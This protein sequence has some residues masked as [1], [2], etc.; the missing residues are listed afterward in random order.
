MVK[1]E[2]LE[3]GN[4]DKCCGCN[5]CI[6]SCPRKCLDIIYDEEG[7]NYPI[8]K[9]SDMCIH[10]GKCKLVCPME[11]NKCLN[12]NRV[13]YGMVNKNKGELLKSSS[14]GVFIQLA[15]NVLKNNGIVYGVTFS[16]NK[17]IYCR[18]DK[19]EDLDQ[20]LGSKYIQA[21]SRGIYTKVRNDLRNGLKVLICGTPC[22][23]AGLKSFLKK[24]YEQLITTDLIC[25]GVPSQKIFDKYF[26]WLE[27]KNSTQIE[28]FS[29]RDKKVHG[30]GISA[31]YRVKDKLISDLSVSSP[32]V[33]AYL[34]NYLHRPSCYS[35]P[36]ATENRPGDITLG[37]FWEMDSV[38]CK[39]DYK[40][41]IS[42]V[43]INSE[44]GINY[45]NK[46]KSNFFF[47]KMDYER[48]IYTNGALYEAS[49]KTDNRDCIY[50]NI[51]CMTFDSL[52]KKY[53]NMPNPI[54][55]KMKKIIP[56]KIKNN[57]KK[58]IKR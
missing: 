47:Q 51:D 3:T 4:K 46:I 14:G 6:E 2:F 23:V 54:I 17:A 20:V 1:N 5:A 32:Y 21:D 16:E 26:N 35:C 50:R 38:D 28:D 15:L 18:V 58:I 24:E 33:W 57:I 22:F 48:C 49:K 37:D 39:L 42:L 55:V 56:V 25:H 36:Y 34:K 31:T 10:C 30:W 13:F 40:D 9:S 43:K 44:K 19:Y 7:F 8:L 11:E 41:G 29:F 45:F 12:S 52:V 27:E 53:F